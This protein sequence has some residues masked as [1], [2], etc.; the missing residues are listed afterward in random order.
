MSFG[1]EGDS[2]KERGLRNFFREEK[3]ECDRVFCLNLQFFGEGIEYKGCQKGSFHAI[4]FWKLD[5]SNKNRCM[6]E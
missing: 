5:I 1:V 6:G 2:K 4:K 3:L